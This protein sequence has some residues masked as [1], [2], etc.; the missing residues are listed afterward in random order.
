MRLQDMLIHETPEQQ[1][2]CK[3]EGHLLPFFGDAHLGDISVNVT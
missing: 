3:R 2:L 1:M